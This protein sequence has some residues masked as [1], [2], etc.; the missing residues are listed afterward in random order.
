M[1]LLKVFRMKLTP[2]ENILHD[3]FTKRHR[4]YEQITGGKI[5]PD[6]ITQML[7]AE[8]FAKEP[9]VRYGEHLTNLWSTIQMLHTGT[10]RGK[11]VNAGAFK[12]PTLS[13]PPKTTGGS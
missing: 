4:E 9:A 8:G 1:A 11:H 12:T 5:E 2:I 3:I 13:I 10:L 6:E 7:I